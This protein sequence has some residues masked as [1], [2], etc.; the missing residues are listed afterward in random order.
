[1]SV[2]ARALATAGGL[3]VDRVLGEPPAAVHPVAAFGTLMGHVERRLWR[4]DV[5]AGA[6]YAAVGV[7]VGAVAGR[8]VRSTLAAT[9]VAVAGRE[10]R[11]TAVEIG[12]R[13]AGGDLAGARSLLPA[14]VGRD[15]T[16][17]DASQIA[18]AVVESLAEN[19]VDAVVA[20]AFWAMVGGAPAVA[21]H[22][23]VNTMDA[24]VGHRTERYRRFGTGAARLDDVA[25][26]V[27]AR[28]VAAAVA[29]VRPA[30]AAAVVR[31]VRRDAPAHP[32]PNAGVAEAAVAAALGCQ[33]G[34][35]L[36]YGD[37]HEDRPRL[38]DGR[39]PRPVDVTAAVRLADDVERLLVAGLLAVAVLTR[40]ARR[41]RRRAP[42]RGRG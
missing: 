17:L 21:A 14:L 4:D 12:A 36:R 41:R 16:D 30:R 5:R 28:L 18:A 13:A 42:A 22:R 37:R 40:R 26:W 33:L 20:P 2:P 8:A 32:S 1:V 9:A 34:G 27:P 10:L 11:R 19:T 31:T 6:A 29:V 15:P 38:G 3:L 24:M 35:P 7:V 23:A 25:N 39:R